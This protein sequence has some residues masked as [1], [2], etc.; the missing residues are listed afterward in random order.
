MLIYDE[1]TVPGEVEY[2]EKKAAEIEEQIERYHKTSLRGDWMRDDWD[3]SI[4][5]TEHI[6][7]KFGVTIPKPVWDYA[8]YDIDINNS[9]KL[10]WFRDEV[11]PIDEPKIFDLPADDIRSS[12]PEWD[13]SF[14]PESVLDDV[15]HIHS[16]RY[17]V[18]SEIERMNSDFYSIQ[19]EFNLGDSKCNNI[20]KIFL[21]KL[22][23]DNSAVAY[24]ELEEKL[25]DFLDLYDLF[26]QFCYYKPWYF[27]LDMTKNDISDAIH[28][29]YLNASKRSKRIIPDRIDC[30]NLNR[31]FEVDCYPIKNYECLYQGKAGNLVIR[32]LFD[33]KDMKI[34]MAYPVLKEIR[35]MS[36]HKEYDY[37]N[38]EGK[39]FTWGYFRI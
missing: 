32:F 24:T 8:I 3:I 26:A 2:A 36:D 33:Y 4:Q 14:F 7:G 13:N 9:M 27:P 25:G 17:R 35:E 23:S 10:D 39:Y 21:D 11:A 34:V 16:K 5:I 20:M 37:Y 30:E 28:E 22:K 38:K 12:L 15:I 31:G 1:W 6:V 19:K 29:A 18:V